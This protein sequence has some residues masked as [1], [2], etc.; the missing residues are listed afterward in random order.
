MW[1][2]VRQLLDG[3]SVQRKPQRP[4]IG[5][6]PQS[7]LLK[8]LQ[9]FLPRIQSANAD[10]A[11]HSFT[12]SAVSIVDVEQG[13]EQECSAYSTSDSDSEGNSAG[14][15]ASQ[16]IEM[17]IACGVLELHDQAAITAAEAAL[18]N[19]VQSQHGKW[20]AS[21]DSASDDDSDSSSSKD[22]NET[23][24]HQVAWDEVQPGDACIQRQDAFTNDSKQA[25]PSASKRRHLVVKT[26]RPN[27][28]EM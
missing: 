18:A 12:E 24:L 16:H 9:Q 26:R 23:C 3:N 10:L 25:L 6:L 1:Y 4:H 27:I 17:D 2:V 21:S 5:D 13:S 20:D 7:T 19:A 15:Q 28:Q 14:K 8:Q 11:E 22:G